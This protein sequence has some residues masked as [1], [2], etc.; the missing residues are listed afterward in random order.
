MH[1]INLCNIPFGRFH[2][3]NETF[4]DFTTSKNWFF[5]KVF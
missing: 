1:S 4:P 2:V 5:I 3:E